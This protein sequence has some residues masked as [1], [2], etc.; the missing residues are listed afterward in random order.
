MRIVLFHFSYPGLV[1]SL[2]RFS[3]LK[4]RVLKCTQEA[5]RIPVK[6]PVKKT[7]RPLS[8]RNWDEVSMREAVGI[9]HSKG[10]SVSRAAT[11]H[12][13]PRSTLNDHC[14]G[15]VLPGARS[16]R[17]TILSSTEEQDLVQFL[18]SSAKIGYARTR[19]EVI[20]IVERMLSVRD[21]RAKQTV[22]IGWWNKFCKRHPEL[23]LR[24][25]ATLSLSRASA[26]TKECIDNYFDVLE[27]VLDDYDLR[28][29]PSLI[30]NMDESGFPLDPKPLKTIHQRGE[31]NPVSITSGSKS[32]VTVVACV[33]ASGQTIPPLINWKR[34]TMSPE[35]AVGEIPGTQY[36]FSD[37]GW[38]KAKLFDSWFRKHF[39]RYIPASQP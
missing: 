15:R 7:N 31:K 34:R 19:S 21:D 9:V 29:Q 35:M 14:H 10:M 6:H 3:P 17:P 26:S 1:P 18:L 33:S 16:G 36:G 32:Q 25:P 38:M 2:G 11:L 13:I 23:V 24:T 8:Y 28:D 12:G 37:S 30:F 5:S 4:N 22:T 27:Q 39:M 20:S